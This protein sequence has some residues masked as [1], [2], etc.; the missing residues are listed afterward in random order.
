M[1]KPD[2]VTIGWLILKLMV[3]TVVILYLVWRLG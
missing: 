2:L 3:D 1:N